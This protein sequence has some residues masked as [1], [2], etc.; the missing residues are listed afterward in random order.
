MGRARGRPSKASKQLYEEDNRSM[1]GRNSKIMRAVT[2]K[3]LVIGGVG[4]VPLLKAGTKENNTTNER[5]LIE[6]ASI[7]KGKAHA[8]TNLEIWPTLPTSSGDSKA[9]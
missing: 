7:S 3:S 9:P 5:K 2:P 1:E 6:E 4:I 8:T